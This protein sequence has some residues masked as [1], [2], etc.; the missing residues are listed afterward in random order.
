MVLIAK[1]KSDKVSKGYRLKK[2]THRLIDK[3][4]LIMNADQDTVITMAIKK[5][6]RELKYK[7]ILRN[8]GKSV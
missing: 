5:L 6:H 1:P 7:N 2:S 3:L 8:R 4:Q